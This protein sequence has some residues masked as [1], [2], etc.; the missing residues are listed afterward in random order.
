[1]GFQILNSNGE[2]ISMHEL[3]REAAAFWGKEVRIKYYATPTIYKGD[4]EF[5]RAMAD[6]SGN[7]FDVIGH[8]IHYQLHECSGWANIVATMMATS[9]G[10]KFIDTS[11]GYKDRPVD[12]K[13]LTAT[14]TDNVN[15]RINFPEELLMPLYGTMLF[16]KPYIELI[17]HWQSKG[18]TPKQ[19]R[20]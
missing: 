10:M 11:E 6:T 2:P 4:D 5:K 20:D 16:Y 3:D 18:Y 15:Y 19:V 7:W 8:A 13:Y 14:T 9:I 12:V 17:N 1:M